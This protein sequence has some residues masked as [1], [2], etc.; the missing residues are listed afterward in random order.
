[1]KKN[2]SQL[3]IEEK[4][5]PESNMYSVAMLL[6]NPFRPDPRVYKQA[7]SLVR[8]GYKV[9]IICWD[10]LAEYKPIE[11]LDGIEIIRIRLGSKYSFGSQQI[12]Y[13]PR[14]WLR[15]LNML[16]EIKPD[17][18]HCHDLDTA[19]IGYFYTRI[20]A[21]P[22][23]FDAHECYPEQ[24][25]PQVNSVVYTILLFLERFLAPRASHIVTVG[26][27]LAQHL[28]SFGGQV[29]V[30]GNYPMIKRPNNQSTISRQ[31]M[32]IRAD[33]FVVAYIG[34]F[35]L[36]REII[37]L[38]HASSLNPEVIYL[39]IGDG[40]Q[41]QRIED[42]IK[43]YPKVQYLGLVPS[44]DITQYMTLVDVIYYGLNSDSGNSYYSAPNALFKAMAAGKPMITTNT[45]EISQIVH[46]EKCGM[47]ID[48]PLPEEIA[49]AINKL[50]CPDVYDRMARN[51]LYAAQGK[52]NW[53]LAEK[54]LLLVYSNLIQ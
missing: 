21:I 12:F 13:L 25:K 41:R 9:T 54:D 35:T 3:S 28:E 26:K 16:R 39:I 47:V 2:S 4:F 52:Y 49:Q 34:G 19:P 8:A 53:E 17:I 11:N 51:A 22:W 37:P 15:S 48:H 42:E 31:S 23:I 1:M 20:R 7:L 44:E 14:F 32:N 24:I 18:I 46:D 6:T 10:R 38:I 43:I 33:D 30:V 29:A 45:G 36:A 50:R 27:R 40:P 5:H